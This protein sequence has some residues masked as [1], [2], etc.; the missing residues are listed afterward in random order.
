MVEWLTRVFIVRFNEGRVPHNCQR[1][2]TA[3]IYKGRG[4]SGQCKN[5]RGIRLLVKCMEEC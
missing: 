4:N 3:P 1:G 2:I 5:D